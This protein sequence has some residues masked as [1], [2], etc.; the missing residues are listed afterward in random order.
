MLFH[1]ALSPILFVLVLACREL[2]IQL[3]EFAS[4]VLLRPCLAALLP[5]AL[6]HFYDYHHPVHGFW[7][8]L[9]SGL[10]LVIL[11]LLLWQ[12]WV[13]RTDP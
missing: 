3:S 5:L 6:L 11:S 7:P 12:F 2:S 1:Q 8:L 10:S 4:R 9:L 13:R